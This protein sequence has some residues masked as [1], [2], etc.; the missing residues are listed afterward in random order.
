MNRPLAALLSVSMLIL[1]CA[2]PS[3][4]ITPAGSRLPMAERATADEPFEP[5]PAS[6]DLDVRRV[7]LGERLFADPQLS[8]DGDRTC[9]DCHSLSAGGI[10]PGEE[11]S[12]HPLNE[13]GPY[14]VPTV[15]NVAFNF[16][17]NWQG[18]FDTLEE[19]LGGLMM[20]P[21][22]MDAGTWPALEERL[23]PGYDADF[24]SAGYAEGVSEESIR[25]AI[26]V[27]QRSLLTP[28]SPFDL[29]LRGEQALG[30]D[31]ERGYRLFRDVGCVSCHQ[32]TNVGGNLFQ[33][34]GVLDDAFGGRELV[35]RDYGRMV[36]TGREE[37]A[38]VF[39]VP[40]LRNVEVTA[41]Y[42]HDGSA[43]T[44]EEAIRHMGRVQLA[45]DLTDEEVAE[46]AAFLR[47]LTGR[48]RGESLSRGAP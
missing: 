38:H 7:A 2:E 30:E 27:F 13:T 10:V 14:N 39:R 32:G 19:H 25:D 5:I 15:F 37:D 28:D 31:A 48:F 43:A 46:L 40:S 26:S 33:R 4:A 21:E 29:Y 18:K 8:G 6:L 17:Y 23:R 35:E 42:F 9:V 3:P 44:L 12:N 11:R 41:P 45:V 22:V 34:F 47:S 16:K 24:R 1:G 36:V 20:K